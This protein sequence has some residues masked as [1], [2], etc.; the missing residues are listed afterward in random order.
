MPG[1]QGIAGIR[2]KAIVKDNAACAIPEVSLV[3]REVETESI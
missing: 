3:C 1:A 2:K